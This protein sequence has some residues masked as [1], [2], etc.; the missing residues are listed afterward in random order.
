MTDA[1]IEAQILTLVCKLQL[2][3]A[4]RKHIAETMQAFAQACQYVQDTL[5][6]K[7]RNKGRMQTLVYRDIRTRFGLSANLTM[8]AIA[9]VSTNRKAAH[10]TG[11]SVKQFAA[12]SIDYDQRIFSFRERDWTVSMTLL[13]G[14]VR[15]ALRLGTYQRG[16]LQGAH[17]TSA[18]LCQHPDGQFFLHI[19]VKHRPPSPADPQDVLGVDLGR[20]DIAHTSDDVAWS[21][22]TL[23]TVRDRFAHL[24]TVLQRKASKGTRSTRR[25]CRELLHRL[26]RRER[27]FQRHTNHVISK[28]LVQHAVTRHAALALED[29]TG[30]RERTNRQRRTKTERRRSNSWAFSQLRQFLAYK[31]QAAGVILHLVSAAYTSQVCHVCLYI[32]SRAGKR[33]T[34]SNPVCG[35]KG[36]A[37]LN[38]AR[39]IRTL[40]LQ[41]S[42]ARGPWLHCPLDATAGLLKVHAL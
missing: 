33:F 5:E 36:D 15:F 38:G 42:Q 22:A 39:N 35:W 4:Q 27:R 41:V 21:G 10:V 18:Q 13:Q 20:M 37:D 25:R 32:G 30:I 7:L 1:V 19:Q 29:L 24:R 34:C 2:D 17:P 8:R 9:R 11:S 16:K 6:P 26:S 3:E 31:A 23:R 14:R 28:H 12:S 40:G